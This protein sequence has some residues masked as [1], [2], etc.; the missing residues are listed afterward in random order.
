VADHSAT[1]KA[2][3]GLAGLFSASSNSTGLIGGMPQSNP[4]Y[5][6]GLV[7]NITKDNVM[8]EFAKFWRALTRYAKGSK[9]DLIVVGDEWY[10]MLWDLFAG[11]STVAGKFDYSAARDIAYKRLE[12]YNI[13]PPQNCFAYEDMM[14]MNDVVFAELD[15]EDPTASVPWTKQARFI[16][17]KY[18]GLGVVQDAEM[19][20][21]DM[22][23]NQRLERASIHGEYFTWTNL[24]RA[25]GVMVKT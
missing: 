17:T 18:A 12:K 4:F 22:P 23:Y 21:H 2:F 14:I 9:P 7:T 11:T 13:A 6:H 24:P 8:L 15:E 16:N 20:A 1:P 25:H 3:T 5:R 19:V 10:E